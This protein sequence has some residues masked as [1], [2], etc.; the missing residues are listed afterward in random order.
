MIFGKEGNLERK[1]VSTLEYK[2]HDTILD[3]PTDQNITIIAK[4]G[5]DQESNTISRLKKY[6]RIIRTFG[7][8][9]SFHS[10]YLNKI[11][12]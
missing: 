6:I 2:L 10:F 3:N 7:C 11:N 12:I 9:Q 4:K 1:C 8:Y 5:K